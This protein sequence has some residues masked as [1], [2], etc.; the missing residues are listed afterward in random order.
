MLES[1]F[2]MRMDIKVVSIVQFSVELRL[3][4]VVVKGCIEGKPNA[5]CKVQDIEMQ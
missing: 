3:F 2:I 4:I 5:V 1:K